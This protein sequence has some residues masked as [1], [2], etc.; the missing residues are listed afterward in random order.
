MSSLGMPDVPADGL[1]PLLLYRVM[2]RI[3]VH[4][5]RAR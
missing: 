2:G 1:R 5:M 4:L 3:R